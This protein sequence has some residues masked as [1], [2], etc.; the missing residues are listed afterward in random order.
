MRF[1][2]AL[3]FLAMVA[4]QPKK[5][6]EA[7]PTQTATVQPTPTP[8]AEPVACNLL[9]KQISESYMALGYQILET[10]GDGTTQA[11]AVFWDGK[12]D[13]VEIEILL[14]S[15]VAPPTQDVVILGKCIGAAGEM[16][17]YKRKVPFKH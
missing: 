17:H 15:V 6:P 4:C 5:E 13:F 12:T 1:L 9:V 7:M 11:Y 14:M 8:T 2:F 10:G 16:T 3:L